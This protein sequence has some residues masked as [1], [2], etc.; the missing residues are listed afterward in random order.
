[1]ASIQE[2]SFWEIVFMYSLVIFTEGAGAFLCNGMWVIG[3]L[4]N[5]GEFDRI[6][7]RPISPLVQML[8]S[9]IVIGGIGSIVMGGAMMIQAIQHVEMEWSFSKIGWLL[10][11]LIP[12]IAIRNIHYSSRMLSG[13]LDGEHE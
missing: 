8:P 2:W 7:A 9:N 13:L 4:V 5:K 12:G 11:F 6:L 1:M 3:G 10:L